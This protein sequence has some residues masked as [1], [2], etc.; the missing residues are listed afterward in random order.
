[1]GRL[2]V[3]QQTRKGPVLVDYGYETS[4]A[5][6]EDGSRAPSLGECDDGSLAPSVDRRAGTEH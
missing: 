5:E 2:Y 1:M 6:D 3:E 4:D